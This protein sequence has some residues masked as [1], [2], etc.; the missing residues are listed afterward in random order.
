MA[1]PIGQMLLTLACGSSTAA[2]LEDGHGELW[3]AGDTESAG[4]S[5][6]EGFRPSCAPSGG[7]VV[8]GGRLP[9]GAAS[10]EVEDISGQLT[11]ATCGGGVWIA[12]VSVSGRLGEPPVTRFRDTN[13]G[14]V[15]RPAFPEV[16]VA[17]LEDASVSCPA[18]G[19]TSWLAVIAA[20]DGA[21]GGSAE[22]P[23]AAICDVCGYEV[24]GLPTLYAPTNALPSDA[25]EQPASSEWKPQAAVPEVP[26]LSFEPF[27]LSIEWDGTRSLSGF[28][29]TGAVVTSISLNH[30]QAGQA[31][32]ITTDRTPHDGQGMIGH[33]R[34]ARTRASGSRDIPWPDGL[35]K[36]AL[37][38]WLWHADREERA[39]ALLLKERTTPLEVSG[40]PLDFVVVGSDRIWG[41]AA[42]VDVERIEICSRGVLAGDLHL[43][44]IADLAPYS[45]R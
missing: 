4:A 27:G 38:L 37:S 25:S 1:H 36:R 32:T 42:R 12:A 28:G 2:V 44:R 5:A 45:A 20:P 41:A 10:V 11:D 23:N 21:F 31:V 26:P 19:S 3:L 8:V 17:S 43:V 16:Q 9:P 30:A 14:L 40:R 7:V 34:E 13:G 18:C 33:A 29:R 35:S 39:A 22:G 24:E 15:R 6:L